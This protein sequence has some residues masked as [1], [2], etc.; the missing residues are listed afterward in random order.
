MRR[1]AAV[2]RLAAVVAGVMVLGVVSVAR[3]IG[4]MYE[5]RLLWTWVVGALAMAVV[6]WVAWNELRRR[7]PQ[8]DSWISVLALV[9][10]AALGVAQVVAVSNQP[11]SDWD[12][13]RGARWCVS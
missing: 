5:Y 1:D 4:V 12:S 11:T 8:S 9:A 10:V 6:G 3:T 2:L 7:W 13:R